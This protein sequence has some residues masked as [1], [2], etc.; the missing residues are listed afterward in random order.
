MNCAS[1]NIE[2]FMLFSSL[3]I[4]S[5]LPGDEDEQFEE[6]KELIIAEIERVAQL[7]NFWYKLTSPSCV[8]SDL[9]FNFHA[10]QWSSDKFSKKREKQ[11]IEYNAFNALAGSWVYQELYALVIFVEL[12]EKN[13]KSF[14]THVVRELKNYV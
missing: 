13:K 14:H 7:S 9:S 4:C 1:K 2:N 3:M 11:C 8:C 6:E 12:K 10:L 5:A